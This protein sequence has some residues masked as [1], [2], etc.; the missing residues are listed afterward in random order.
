[1]KNN[2]LRT[3]KSKQKQREKGNENLEQQAVQG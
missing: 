3:L 1:M 2:Y